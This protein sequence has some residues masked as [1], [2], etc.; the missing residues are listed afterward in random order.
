[1]GRNRRQQ[2]AAIRF[3]PALKAACLCL[4]IGGSAVGYVWQ[5]D[6]LRQL[7]EQ[8]VQCERRLAELRVA[9]EKLQ[10]QLNDLRSPANVER[11][12]QRLNLG[13]TQPRPDQVLRLVEPVGAPEPPGPATPVHFAAGDARRFPSGQ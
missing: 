5:K 13:L 12:V 3:G 9:N 7:S 1:M 4:M 11:L 2:S 10:R 8:I 6:Q